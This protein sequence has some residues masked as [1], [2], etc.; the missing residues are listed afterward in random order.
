VNYW[1]GNNGGA[2]ATGLTRDEI[3][4]AVPEYKDFKDAFDTLTAF[5]N[6][7]FEFY[8]RQ[9]RLVD[10]GTSVESGELPD[11]R[12][13]AV[14][15]AE[16]LHAF[17][18]LSWD[19]QGLVLDAAAYYDELARR[20]VISVDHSGVIRSTASM[21]RSRPYQWSFGP[22]LDELL[23]SLQEMACKSLVGKPANHGGPA[24][25][26]RTR[27]FGILVNTAQDAPPANVAPL[28]RALERCGSGPIKRADFKTREDLQA[29]EADFQVSGVT[30]II[31]PCNVGFEPMAVA[32]STG[33][34]PEWITT[35]IFVEGFEFLYR[36]FSPPE[37][38]SHL[39][40]LGA[41]NKINT[42]ADRPSYWAMHEQHPETT[43][44]L[45]QWNAIYEQMLLLASGI[46]TAGPHLTAESFEHGLFSTRFPNP[47]AAAAPYWQATIKLAPGD[48]TMI[49]DLP[50]VWWSDQAHGYDDSAG[51]TSPYD[52][53]AGGFCYVDRG[54]R[55]SRGKWPAR[56]HPFFDPIAPCT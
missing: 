43:Q 55:W 4:V 8:G 30:S 53:R 36:A 25:V 50:L 24:V 12:A 38:V 42:K 23:E 26:A 49:D 29:A 33:Y 32:S 1:Q 46:Q 10:V 41:A 56:E 9:I 16:E 5:F 22:T 13:T 6:R 37:Q 35:G 51:E 45:S 2:T 28:Q 19:N 34:E 39:F 17:A 7:R 21:E 54:A 20:G 47:G 14:R 44:S 31:C 27:Q 11:M 3:R 15:V 48:H 18:S 40:G 52:S